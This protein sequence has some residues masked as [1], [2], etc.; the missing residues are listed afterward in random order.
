MFIIIL[1]MTHIEKKDDD[2]VDNY[3][4]EDDIVFYDTGD[5]DADDN[6]TIMTRSEFDSEHDDRTIVDN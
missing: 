1:R 6:N 3:S 4:D 5:N 2:V